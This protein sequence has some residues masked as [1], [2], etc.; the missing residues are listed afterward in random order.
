MSIK[1]LKT[2]SANIKNLR[3]SEW[4][5]LPHIIFING[6]GEFGKINGNI[7]LYKHKILIKLK[8]QEEF[9]LKQKEILRMFKKTEDG[10]EY[11]QNF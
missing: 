8:P 7:N 1:T 5:F 10:Y 3:L 9:L 11:E 2:F 6:N 4:I